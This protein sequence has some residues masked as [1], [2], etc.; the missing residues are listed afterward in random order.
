MKKLVFVICS[1]I[2]CTF[3]YVHRLWLIITEIESNTSLY[4]VNAST[5]PEEERAPRQTP[6]SADSMDQ[7]VR[8]TVSRD[9]IIMLDVS[10]L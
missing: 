2:I 4:R 5:G 8:Q 9:I 7:N 3:N 6:P 10:H 1:V